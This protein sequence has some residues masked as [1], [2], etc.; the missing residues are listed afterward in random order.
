MAE[1]IRIR[2]TTL[3]GVLLA[4]RDLTNRIDPPYPAC[5][6][7][8]LPAPGHEGYKTRHFDLESDGTTIVSQGVY[9]TLLDHIDHGGFDLSDVNP[10][11]N[12]PAQGI[13]VGGNGQ[14]TSNNVRAFPPVQVISQRSERH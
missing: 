14:A 10:V 6:R 12:P 5:S 13:S 4:V 1:G 9:D 7:C 8:L 3:S 11:L 2:H